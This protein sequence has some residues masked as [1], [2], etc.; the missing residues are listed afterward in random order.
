ME[1]CTHSVPH[2]RIRTQ[3]E[4][5]PKPKEYACA[6]RYALASH[7]FICSYHCKWLH[8]AAVLPPAVFAARLLVCVSVVCCVVMICTQ[9][10]VEYENK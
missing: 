10:V 3:P 7:V 8:D 2:V 1:M 9:C 4:Y 5:K 6:T